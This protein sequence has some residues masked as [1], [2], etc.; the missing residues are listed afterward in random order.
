[1]RLSTLARSA[2]IAVALL[3]GVALT[4]APAHAAPTSDFYADSGDRCL[5]GTAK[6]T[7]D[8]NPIT[9]TITPGVAAAGSVVDRPTP[10]D[11]RVCANDLLY[12]VVTFSAYTRN[13]LVDT[14]AAKADNGT[15]PIKLLLTGRLTPIDTVV[16]EVCRHST[17][18]TFV[19]V[20]YCGKRVVYTRPGIIVL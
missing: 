9:V 7:F 15:A 17:V 14:D 6:G 13:V 2:T 20:D 18:P 19:P 16:V 8:W 1:M 4:A 3:S 5:Y 12:T 11:S 10:S